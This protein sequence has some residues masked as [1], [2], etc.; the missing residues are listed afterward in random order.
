[1]TPEERRNPKILNASR[2][3]RIARGAGYTNNAKKPEGELEGV[4][5]I[6][7]LLKQFRE[8]QAEIEQAITMFTLLHG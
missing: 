3:K 5:E 1:M 4:Q 6:N 8:M 7:A 2:K